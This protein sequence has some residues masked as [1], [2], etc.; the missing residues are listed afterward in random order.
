[1]RTKRA[2]ASVRHPVA[3]LK[4]PQKKKKKKKLLRGTNQALK[5]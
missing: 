3:M 5:T 2:N 4:R 1:M